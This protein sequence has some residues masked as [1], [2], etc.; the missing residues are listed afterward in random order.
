MSSTGCNEHRKGLSTTPRR[1]KMV[2][3][4]SVLFQALFCLTSTTLLG[5]LAW[6]ALQSRTRKVA[7]LPITYWGNNGCKAGSS[8]ITPTWVRHDLLFF[9]LAGCNG[10][11]LGGCL[12]REYN[13]VPLPVPWKR[14]TEVSS[15]LIRNNL[16]PPTTLPDS[17]RL[18]TTKDSHMGHQK[19]DHYPAPKSDPRPNHVQT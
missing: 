11:P 5:Q 4:S 2:T 13:T 18:E 6:R 3:K 14:H 10:S 9:L 19:G 17:H 12:L 15:M 7:K 1:R 8:Q 16:R